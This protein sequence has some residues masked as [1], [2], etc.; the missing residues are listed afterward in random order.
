MSTEPTPSPTEAV[1]W[2]VQQAFIDALATA[3]AASHRPEHIT[4]L[5]PDAN[6]RNV[7]ARAALEALG[8]PAD[9]PVSV[10]RESIEIATRARQL[11][12]TAE[13]MRALRLH[14]ADS[15]QAVIGALDY[16]LG[17]SAGSTPTEP[18]PLTDAGN[19]AV[20]GGQAKDNPMSAVKEELCACGH[21]YSAHAAGCGDR[22]CSVRDG[23]CLFITCDCEAFQR[24]RRGPA[25]STGSPT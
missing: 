15:T 7:F 4:K 2:A 6:A 22:E 1:V 21:R 12:E 3:A 11:N 10:L 8:V 23:E 18:R 16:I 5:W 17:G 19:D 24:Q 25:P 9:M 20:L 14:R 13:A